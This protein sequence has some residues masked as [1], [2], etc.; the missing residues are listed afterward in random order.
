MQTQMAITDRSRGRRNRLSRISEL[1]IWRTADLMLKQYPDTAC[2][3]AAQWAD[4][5]YATGQMFNSRFWG[6]V[7]RQLANLLRQRTS[8]DTVN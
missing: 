2:L 1:S 4:S 6:R 5:S 7:E 3:V 8:V